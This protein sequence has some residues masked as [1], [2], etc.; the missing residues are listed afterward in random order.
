VVEF[1]ELDLQLR[2]GRHLCGVLPLISL[3][4]WLKRLSNLSYPLSR[5]HVTIT[6]HVNECCVVKSFLGPYGV[7]DGIMGT[8]RFDR[9]EY[10]D[11][12]LCSVLSVPLPNGSSEACKFLWGEP[13]LDLAAGTLRFRAFYSWGRGCNLSNLVSSSPTLTVT[14]EHCAPRESCILDHASPC[15]ELSSS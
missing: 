9:T 13:S 15:L 8:W 6:E 10:D 3:E 11:A 5:E 7:E 4:V 1:L 2:V 12:G 14:S